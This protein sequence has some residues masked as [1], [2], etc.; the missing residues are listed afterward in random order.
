MADP[1]VILILG[2]DEYQV[3]LK[4]RQVVE[5][6]VPPTERDLAL[7]VFDG[8]VDTV[9]AA[10]ALIRQAVEAVQT[11]S[12][13]GGSK[14]VWLREIE[15]LGSSRTSDAVS[16]QP[17]VE[18]LRQTVLEGV[19]EGHVLVLSGSRIAPAG[20]VPKAVAAVAKSGL[21]QVIQFE[22]RRGRRLV[23]DEALALIGATA[24]AQGRTVPADV[25]EHL[26]ARCGSDSRLL[27][28]ELEKLLLY[29]GDRA[30]TVA[31]IGEILTASKD[32][33]VWDLL[34]AFGMRDL[35]GTLALLRRLLDAGASEV[36]LAMQLIGRT[37]DLLL[38]RD[39]TDRRFLA[40][41][42]TLQWRSGLPEPLPAALADLDKRW[43][44]AAK[45]SFVQGKLSDQSRRFKRIELRRARH[46]LLTA[47]ERL[48]SL[49]V[50][51]ALVLELATAD[52]LRSA[53]SP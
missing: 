2:E 22:A 21:G 25:C 50:P 14:T 32:D 36:F 44:P 52:A 9:D 28:S 53:G 37:N 20:V 38:L 31:D 30:P 26:V 34:D 48:V 19:P 42:R 16:L 23:R 5:D 45:H 12:F 3:G 40:G 46:V 27:T 49:S 17:S 1:R 8:R 10:A 29:A 39:S 33:E 43:N 13:L 18:M 35:P 15:F 6:L 11:Q 7:E 47:Y 51:G 41:A 4:A 24:A